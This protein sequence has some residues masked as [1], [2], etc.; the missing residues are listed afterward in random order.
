MPEVFRKG[1]HVVGPDGRQFTVKQQV[2]PAGCVHLLGAIHHIGVRFFVKP[3]GSPCVW[4]VYEDAGW[5]NLRQV[6]KHEDL[7]VARAWEALTR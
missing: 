7:D 5:G 6:F 3:R 4:K 2:T 1:A